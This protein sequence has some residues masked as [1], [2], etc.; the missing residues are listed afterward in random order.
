MKAGIISNTAANASKNVIVKKQEGFVDK[1]E[2][3]FGKGNTFAKD[4]KTVDV[5]SKMDF[6]TLEGGIHTAQF[7]KE[8]QT[9]PSF[10]T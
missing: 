5:Q 8:T 10:P 1:Q 3:L 4:K 7:L 6:P 9:K 2:Y